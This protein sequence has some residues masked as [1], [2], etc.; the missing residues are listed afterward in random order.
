MLAR[1]LEDLPEKVRRDPE[2]GPAVYLLTAPLIADK[3]PDGWVNLERRFI[4]WELLIPRAQMWSTGEKMYVALAFNLWSGNT[5]Y[6]WI[7]P[8]DLYLNPYRWSRTLTDPS[9]LLEAIGLSCGLVVPELA[10][11]GE[12]F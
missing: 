5:D 7:T 4:N 9:R 12:A 6:A 1:T 11:L 8:G 2:F 3:I 10:S